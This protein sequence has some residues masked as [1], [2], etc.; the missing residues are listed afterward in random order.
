MF[1]D[2][3][4]ANVHAEDEIGMV[5]RVVGQLAGAIDLYG[6][7]ANAESAWGSL[8]AAA[9]QEIERAEAG[10]DF[11]LAW[12]RTLADAARSEDH[13]AMVRR[14]LDGSA[15]F[16]GLSV[17]TELRWHFVSSLASAGVSDAED[18]VRAEME[19]DP[20]DQGRRHAAAALASRPSEERPSERLGSGSPASPTSPRP[21][22]AR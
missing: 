7:P 13:L 1:L 19:R 6:D 2:L 22:W 17:D 15:T 8:A 5:Q 16:E 21:C 4:L 3:V 14:L 9:L 12:V 18:L 10:S 20:T 11:Q